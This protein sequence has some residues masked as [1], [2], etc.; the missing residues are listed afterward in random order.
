LANPWSFFYPN[1]VANSKSVSMA[2]TT[3]NERTNSTPNSTAFAVAYSFS[4]YHSDTSTNYYPSTNRISFVP[5]N[6]RA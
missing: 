3:S 2:N 5:A 1:H 6:T 4:D